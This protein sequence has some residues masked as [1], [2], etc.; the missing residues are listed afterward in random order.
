VLPPAALLDELL[1][2]LVPDEL[3][4][5]YFVDWEEL[6]SV[7]TSVPNSLQSSHSS[8]SAPS[9]FTVVSDG[10]SLPHISHWGISPRSRGCG[11]K[12]T[13]RGAVTSSGRAANERQ[14]R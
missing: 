9:T 13:P 8:S 3:D 6:D 7:R 4:V 14:R 1:D 11:I 5:E 10:C 2:P 12:H